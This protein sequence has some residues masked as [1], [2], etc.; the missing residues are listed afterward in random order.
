MDLFE[1][2]LNFIGHKEQ[3]FQQILS[4]KAKIERQQFVNSDRGKVCKDQAVFITSKSDE[5]EGIKEKI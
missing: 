3:E 1:Q 2:K 4:Y 5:L